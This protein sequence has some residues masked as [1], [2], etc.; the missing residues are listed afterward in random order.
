MAYRVAPVR[1]DGVAGEW[2]D[3]AVTLPQPLSIHLKLNQPF[4]GGLLDY[5]A[6]S[7]GA[8]KYANP[9]FSGLFSSFLLLFPVDIT[10]SCSLVCLVTLSLFSLH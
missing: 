10:L 1:T 2:S 8:K 7:G 6:T 5:I 3:V 9:H 4:C